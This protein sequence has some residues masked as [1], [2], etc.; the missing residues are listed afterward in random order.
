MH[1][2]IL[3]TVSVMLPLVIFFYQEMDLKKS[4]EYPQKY[5]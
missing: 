3:F 4:T 1:D 2:A 5:F